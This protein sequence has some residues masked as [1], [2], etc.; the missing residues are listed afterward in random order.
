M[1]P[2]PMDR[3]HRPD[4]FFLLSHSIIQT[5]YVTKVTL[6]VTHFF[7]VDTGI[8]SW[9]PMVSLPNRDERW[10]LSTPQA[11]CRWAT[12][13][14]PS[15]CSIAMSMATTITRTAVQH[16]GLVAQL[17]HHETENA[18]FRMVPAAVPIFL[19]LYQT[20]NSRPLWFI[21]SP[22]RGLP[23]ESTQNTTQTI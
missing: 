5:T 14:C 15:T 22:T 4:D 8:L 7:C 21:E 23:K 19:T 16:H 18:A 11:I 13:P 12:C 20:H 3:Q 9:G 6:K 2:A 1:H 10:P 17:L